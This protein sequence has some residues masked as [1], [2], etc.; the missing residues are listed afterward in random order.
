MLELVQRTNQISIQ[1]YIES[2]V[3]DISNG[4]WPT[5]VVNIQQFYT[6]LGDN[7][8]QANPDTRLQ[9][10]VE[11]VS[12]DFVD[13]VYNTIISTKDDSRLKPTVVLYDDRDGSY[14]MI[15]SAHTSEI[16][17]RLAVSVDEKYWKRPTHVVDF[18]Q[19]NYDL[20]LALRL[21]NKLNN[22]T[23]RERSHEPDD[24]KNELY[25]RIDLLLERKGVDLDSIDLSEEDLMMTKEEK[26][27]LTNEF[28]SAYQSINK[29]M[30]GQW[31]SNH[32]KVGGRRK[33]KISYTDE[34]LEKITK[35][36]ISNK[37]S[38]DEYFVYPRTVD[39]LSGEA[40]AY[41]LDLVAQERVEFFTKKEGNNRSKV[42]I[43]VYASTVT[44]SPKMKSGKVEKSFLE[45]SERYHYAY[46]VEFIYEELPY[47]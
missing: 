19:L 38:S 44:Q 7:V 13:A 26:E 17:M 6:Y 27:S 31:I 47:E 29:A 9:V 33:P 41:G 39:G 5:Q 46:N 45:K 34:Q 1:E 2:V 24:V 4:I 36:R 40:W 12:L 23:Y 28:D 20:S 11:D 18:S 8:W 25:T 15:G 30:I 42:V 10:R 14:R 37:Y 22:P 43:L 32:S 16:C 35:D 3:D 21:G